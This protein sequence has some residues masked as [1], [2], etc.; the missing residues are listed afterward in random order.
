MDRLLGRTALVFAAVG[1]LWGACATSGGGGDGDAD[2]DADTDTDVHVDCD[3]NPTGPGCRCDAAEPD[4]CYTGPAVTRNVGI[5]AEGVTFCVDGEWGPCTGETHP[6]TETAPLNGR[7]DDCNGYVDDGLCT[8]VDDCS[9]SCC[10]DTQVC[11]K[12]Q[13]SEGGDADSDI[14]AQ[15]AA[16]EENATACPYY[17][18]GGLDCVSASD[19]VCERNSN[20][21][22][23]DMC[24]ICCGEACIR[25]QDCGYRY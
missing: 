22:P 21:Y 12:G 17:Y 2:S 15:C 16:E 10:L 18:G 23:D 11:Y 3:L 13:C 8:P 24:D 4:T 5:C 25:Q 19:D 9:G 14:D 20:C 6:G 7:D 1:M